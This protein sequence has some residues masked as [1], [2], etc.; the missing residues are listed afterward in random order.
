MRNEGFSGSKN[1]CICLAMAV[2]DVR[3]VQEFKGYGLRCL[4]IKNISLELLRKSERLMPFPGV[5]SVFVNLS[6]LGIL[7]S[8]DY[9][10]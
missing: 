6:H 1:R 7:F 2:P 8:K 4:H 10:T 5:I 9:R 3:K